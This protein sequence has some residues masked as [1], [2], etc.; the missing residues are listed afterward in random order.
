MTVRHHI[1]EINRLIITDWKG[2]ADVEKFFRIYRRYL[3]KLRNKQEY[4]E[5]NEV[6]N[7]QEIGRLNFNLQGL[8]IYAN[9]TKSFDYPRATKLAMI[10]NP[11]MANILANSYV[12]IRKLTPG[13][14]KKVKVFLNYFDA[15]K[16]IN[17]DE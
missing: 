4:S 15:L 5:Y 13:S 8:K 11:G 1:D 9:Y 17:T 3:K 7:F 14:K 10:V 6:I 12:V 16:W 2:D